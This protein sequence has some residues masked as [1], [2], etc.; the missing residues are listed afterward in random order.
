VPVFLKVES[1]NPESALNFDLNPYRE[2]G[3]AREPKPREKDGTSDR[4]GERDRTAENGG[5][6]TADGGQPRKPDQDQKAEKRTLQSSIPEQRKTD[7]VKRRVRR[8]D[9]VRIEGAG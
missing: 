3:T 1:D 4:N 9:V 6:E 5:T 8:T 7:K 2:M